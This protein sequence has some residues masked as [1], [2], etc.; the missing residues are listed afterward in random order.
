MEMPTINQIFGNK[1]SA[2]ILRILFSTPGKMIN[3]DELAKLAKSGRGNSY[4][5]LSEL[6][7]AG[8]LKKEKGEKLSFIR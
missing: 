6:A 5:A 4:R 7:K 1:T 8:L 3:P 2:R